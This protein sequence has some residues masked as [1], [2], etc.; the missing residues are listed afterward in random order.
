V[1]SINVND[2]TV[3]ALASSIGCVVGKIPFT[4]LGLPL[5]TTKPSVQDLMPMV[6]RIERKVSAN[7]TLMSATLYALILS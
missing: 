1:I 3:Q 7:F 5:G 2:G 4:Y 6:C